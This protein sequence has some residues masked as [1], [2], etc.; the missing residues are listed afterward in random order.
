[1]F[2]EP[3]PLVIQRDCYLPNRHKA[4]IAGILPPF[5]LSMYI[6]LL[7]GFPVHPYHL[8][9]VRAFNFLDDDRL[10]PKN[11]EMPIGIS[12]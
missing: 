9:A 7:L 8:A 10:S 5:F 12:Q 11:E 2:L 1:M 4:K 3:R 6:F